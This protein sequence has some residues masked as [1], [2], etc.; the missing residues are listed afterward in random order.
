MT[1]VSSGQLSKGDEEMRQNI[2]RGSDEEEFPTLFLNLRK[3][4]RRIEV[5]SRYCGKTEGSFFIGGILNPAGFTLHY[6][7]TP[8][9]LI[10]FL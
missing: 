9:S 1:G 5:K 3:E 2:K 4:K 6:L 8:G 7:S 10:Y